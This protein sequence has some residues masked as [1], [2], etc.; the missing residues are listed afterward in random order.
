MVIPLGL[1]SSRGP[2]LHHKVIY[3]CF[4]GLCLGAFPC[5]HFV[6]VG[7]E[8]KTVPRLNSF[9]QNALKGSQMKVLVIQNIFFSDVFVGLNNFQTG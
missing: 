5:L 9:Q 7:L 3:C 6:G 4:S 2:A 8:L 1:N